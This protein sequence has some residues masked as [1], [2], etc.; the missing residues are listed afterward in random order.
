MVTYSLSLKSSAGNWL[1]FYQKKCIREEKYNAI[2]L[3]VSKLYL[4]FTYW[5]FICSD[6]SNSMGSERGILYTQDKIASNRGN[7]FLDYI[8]MCMTVVVV[9]AQ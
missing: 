6:F 5:L 3:L 8:S 1:L 9:V 7:F 2:T 4:I